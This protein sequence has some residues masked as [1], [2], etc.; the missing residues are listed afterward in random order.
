[1]FIQEPSVALAHYP[2]TRR[3]GQAITQAESKKKKQIGESYKVTRR[4]LQRQTIY[5]D[6]QCIVIKHCTS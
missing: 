4:K 2:K 5:P 6:F 3:D 1:M